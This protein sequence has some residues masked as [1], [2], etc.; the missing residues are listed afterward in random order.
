MN[1]VKFTDLLNYDF[2][3]LEFGRDWNW[4]N[5]F[6]NQ[7]YVDLLN[8]KY[9]TDIMSFVWLSSKFSDG[10]HLILVIRVNINNVYRSYVFGAI[11]YTQEITRT[12]YDNYQ[13]QHFGSYRTLSTIY[14][15]IHPI[16][17]SIIRDAINI[18]LSTESDDLYIYNSEILNQQDYLDKITLDNLKIVMN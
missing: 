14:A 6:K 4:A 3:S 15:D 7:Q 1:P 9:N 11:S 5:F 18:D 8:I 12:D 16:K 2:P 17:T 13:P 10:E